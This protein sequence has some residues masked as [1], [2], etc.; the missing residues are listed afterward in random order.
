METLYSRQ[1]AEQLFG[2]AKSDLNILPNILPLRTHS[3]AR[4][5]GLMLLAF[6]A[7]IIYTKLKNV[8]IKDSTLEQLLSNSSLLR[9]LKCKV[10]DGNILVPSEV[11][12]KQP[13]AFEV[14]NI[15]V[16]KNNGG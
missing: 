14:A 6:I 11:N 5:R 3:E 7:L 10:F 16:P 13:L 8:L 15:L 4:F 12:K 1:T 9:N 2:I